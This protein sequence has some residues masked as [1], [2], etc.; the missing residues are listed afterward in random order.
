[1]ACGWSA[2]GAPRDFTEDALRAIEA[3][4][5][6]GNARELENRVKRAA[7]M[8]ELPERRARIDPALLNPS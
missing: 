6:P 2:P 1:M 3:Y 7:I 8:A 5:W 4:R